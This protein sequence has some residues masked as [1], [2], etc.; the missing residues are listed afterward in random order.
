[1]STRASSLGLV[2]LLLPSLLHSEPLAKADPPSLLMGSTVYRDEFLDD[3]YGA[4]PLGYFSLPDDERTIE[5][6]R[7]SLTEKLKG[8]YKDKSFLTRGWAISHA[9]ADLLVEPAVIVDGNELPALS[10]YIKDLCSRERIDQPVLAVSAAPGVNASAFSLY[11]KNFL[12]IT[13]NML[14]SRDAFQIEGIMAHECGHLFHGH[15]AK[16][17]WTG[18]LSLA[19]LIALVWYETHK[20]AKFAEG[21]AQHNGGGRA[22]LS[23]DFLR[24]GGTHLGKSVGRLGGSALLLSLLQ[25]YLLRRQEYQADAFAKKAEGEVAA[26]GIIDFLQTLKIGVHEGGFRPFS[27]HPDPDDRIEKLREE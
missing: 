22:F 15:H 20:T 24:K 16:R 13:A 3:I 7:S 27:T 14:L 5:D 26:E 12:V 9:K 18:G 21:Y 4:G 6:L 1:M 19:T 11:G 23:R 10:A 17:M 8:I 2:F 25:F